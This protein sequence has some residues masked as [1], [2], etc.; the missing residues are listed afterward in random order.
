MYKG[1]HKIEASKSEKSGPIFVDAVNVIDS[2]VIGPIV[3]SPQLE[4][5]VGQNSVEQSDT[6]QPFTLAPVSR[7]SSR[8]HV[9]N[10]RYMNYLLLT[11]GGDPECYEEACQSGDA[12][13]WELA[14]KDEMKSLISNQTWE[15]AELPMGK[16]ALHNK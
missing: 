10:R 16:K 12:S 13:K 14:I 1:M 4:E 8:P 2:L 7:R 5:L 9:P 11:D 6:L 3:T 15:L